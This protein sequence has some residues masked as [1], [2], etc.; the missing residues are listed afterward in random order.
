VKTVSDK[1]VRHSLAYGISPGV[2]N[3]ALDFFVRRKER[4][5]RKKKEKKNTCCNPPMGR[6]FPQSAFGL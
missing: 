1:V 2:A 6:V 4:K 3:A 5:R